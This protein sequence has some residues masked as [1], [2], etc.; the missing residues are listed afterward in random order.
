[1]AIC[2]FLQLGLGTALWAAGEGKVLP[3][4]PT[5]MRPHL[6]SSIRPSTGGTWSSWRESRR[7]HEVAEGT[8]APPLGRLGEL[9]LLSLDKRRLCG[10]PTAPS[11]V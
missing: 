10:D 11:R 7:G 3:L 2:G 6:Q 4:C 9:G 8:G 5:Q 1:M